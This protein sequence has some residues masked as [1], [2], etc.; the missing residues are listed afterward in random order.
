[1]AEEIFAPVLSVFVYDDAK[2]DET[3]ELVDTTSPYVNSTPAQLRLPPP[4]LRLA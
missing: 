1:M 4:C 2:W 3:L